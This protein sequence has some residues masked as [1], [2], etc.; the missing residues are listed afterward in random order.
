VVFGQFF[1]VSAM[2]DSHSSSYRGKGLVYH[3]IA[4]ET[5]LSL[6][7]VQAAMEEISSMR[8][9]NHENVVDYPVKSSVVKNLDLIFNA[10]SV[11]R[12]AEIDRI[13]GLIFLGQYGS[14]L[15]NFKSPSDIIKRGRFW[16]PDKKYPVLM[17]PYANW[18]VETAAF[19]ALWHCMPR[20]VWKNTDGTLFGDSSEDNFKP[21]ISQAQGRDKTFFNRC[22]HEWNGRESGI[23]AEQHVKLDKLAVEVGKHLSIKFSK[24]LDQNKCLGKLADDCVLIFYM[25]SSLAPDD[26]DLAK[27]LQKLDSAQLSRDGSFVNSKFKSILKRPDLWPSDA[28]DVNLNQLYKINKEINEKLYRYSS[29]RSVPF[30]NLYHEL[31]RDEQTP[32]SEKTI[33]SGE[34]N[35]TYLGERD[36]RY[37]PRDEKTIIKIK[38]AAWKMLKEQGAIND[39]KMI[40]HFLSHSLAVERFKESLLSSAKKLPACVGL[41]KEW[42]IEDASELASGTRLFITQTLSQMQFS[43]RRELLDDLTGGWNACMPSRLI[44]QSE[45]IKDICR[46][47][48][49]VNVVYL[50]EESSDA[51]HDNYFAS[52]LK[53]PNDFSAYEPKL[54]NDSSDKK[55]VSQQ[56]QLLRRLIRSKTAGTQLWHDMVA[57]FKKQRWKLDKLTLWTNPNRNQALI[58]LYFYDSTG[59]HLPGGWHYSKQLWLVT[60]GHVKQIQLPEGLERIGSGKIARVTDYRNDGLFQLWF[61]RHRNECTGDADDITERDFNCRLKK[62]TIVEIPPHILPKSAKNINSTSDFVSYVSDPGIKSWVKKKYLRSR[63][64]T[65][66]KQLGVMLAEITGLNFGDTDVEWDKG[67]ILSFAAKPYPMNPNLLL[68]ALYHCLQN[69]D[70]RSDSSSQCHNIE[71]DEVGFLLL[72]IDVDKKT[73]L[74]RYSDRQYVDASIRINSSSLELVEKNYSL[75]LR[76]NAFGVQKSIGYSPCAADGN[77]DNFLDLFIEDGTDAFRP[78]LKDFA[79][80]RGRRMGSGSCGVGE[81]DWEHVNLVLDVESV[82]NNDWADLAIRLASGENEAVSRARQPYKKKIGVLRQ[83]QGRYKCNGNCEPFAR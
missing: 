77:S 30:S 63:Q 22:V 15:M 18:P 9:T 61:S 14:H 7:E 55:L 47:W 82:K 79:T 72:L 8:R 33:S 54:P 36:W 65:N 50:E 12:L 13:N 35:W 46:V 2:A 80:L 49:D 66:F 40:K 34:R 56:H 53:N 6:K 31:K 23:T 44:Q 27:L 41:D 39:C 26:A 75:T 5:G 67:D 3:D 37:Y 83:H 1:A 28:L 62:A 59:N 24:F 48:S 17:G 73:I 69:S 74:R 16:F 10:L 20:A 60:P 45:W 64:E 58:E 57:D 32:R 21:I 43:V 42:L 68:A 81:E 78:V 71:D 19:Y 52:I 11:Q 51:S 25:W 70:K 76:I 38:K 4:H 29:V